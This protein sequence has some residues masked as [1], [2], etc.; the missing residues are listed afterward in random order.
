LG[1]EV[2]V[3]V[4]CS[5]RFREISATKVKGIGESVPPFFRM[6]HVDANFWKNSLLGWN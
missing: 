5:V 4:G 3:D 6:K 2:L 1:D